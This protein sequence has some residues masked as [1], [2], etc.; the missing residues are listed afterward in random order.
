MIYIFKST[1]KI[2]INLSQCAPLL[3]REIKVCKSVQRVLRLS[4]KLK[5]K[6]EGELEMLMIND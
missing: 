6:D 2:V 4:T 5:L 1:F 3:M